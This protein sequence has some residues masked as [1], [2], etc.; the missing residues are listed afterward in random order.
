MSVILVEGR[1]SAGFHHH[2]KPSPWGKYFRGP[3]GKMLK[4]T[5]GAEQEPPG[6]ITFW[7]G[8]GSHQTTMHTHL[9]HTTVPCTTLT[10]HSCNT[11]ATLKPQSCNTHATLTRHSHNKHTILPQLSPIGPLSR[12]RCWSNLGVCWGGGGGGVAEWVFSPE[13]KPDPTL[14]SKQDQEHTKY[15]YPNRILILY[16]QFLFVL[17]SIFYNYSWDS[18]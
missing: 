14:I 4:G 10:Q 17:R 13:I 3:V 9:T 8:S 18:C 16:G 1:T 2:M 12:P 15:L 11:H 7:G 5:R 6:A